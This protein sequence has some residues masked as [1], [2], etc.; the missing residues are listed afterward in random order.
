MDL[1]L[2]VVRLAVGTLMM[3]H[4]AQKLFGSFGGHGPTGTGGFFESLE[5]TPGQQ[6]PGSSR[7]SA[8]PV[9]HSTSGRVDAS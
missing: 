7:G 3:G 2:L 4:G 1:G 6:P 5:L 8:P 9:D